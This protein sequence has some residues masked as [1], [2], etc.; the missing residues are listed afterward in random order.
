MSS[1][2]PEARDRLNALADRIEYTH[3]ARKKLA[4]E[5]RQIVADLMFRKPRRP[6]GKTRPVYL[7]KTKLSEIRDYAKRNPDLKPAKIASIFGTDPRRTE[8]ALEAGK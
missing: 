5:L 1:Q 4:D 8:K 7:T 2:I 6:K 3:I